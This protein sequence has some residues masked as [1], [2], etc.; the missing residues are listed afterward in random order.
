[1]RSWCS[2][3]D[4]GR[5]ELLDPATGEPLEGPGA[6]DAARRLMG[7]FREYE[8]RSAEHREGLVFERAVDQDEAMRNLEALGYVQ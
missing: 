4:E 5:V 1:M 7:A 6:D 2:T 3:L 8:S